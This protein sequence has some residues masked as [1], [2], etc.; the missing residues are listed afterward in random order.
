MRPARTRSDGSDLSVTSAD[1]ALLREELSRFDA[2]CG[3]AA[4]NVEAAEHGVCSARD[5][6]LTMKKSRDL[7]SSLAD[8]IEASASLSAASPTW[9][10]D[11][12]EEV[13]PAPAAPPRPSA[14]TTPVRRS[15]RKS[16][17]K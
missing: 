13:D 2:A 12:F 7:L 1:A 16:G 11:G 9:S 17:K 10:D 14:S 3:A 6:F 15:T 4:A 8:R 5:H